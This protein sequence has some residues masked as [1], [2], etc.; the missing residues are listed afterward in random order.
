MTALTQD[1]VR[2]ARG[3]GIRDEIAIATSSKIYVGSLCNVRTTT[4]RAVAATGATGRRVLGVC[5]AF[6]GAYT[7]ATDNK[8][9]ATGNTGGTIRA[10]VEYAREFE[11][12]VKTALRTNTTI[13]LNV[14]VAD[15]ATVGGT[16]IGSAGTRVPVGI[17]T[18]FTNSTKSKA[19]VAVRQF[20]TTNVST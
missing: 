13:G 15:D 18:K 1:V 20:Y 9:G 8:G 12:D 2:N 10:V 4:G 17:L 11:F 16:A 14:F 5:V 6:A 7:Q 3:Q 19:Y